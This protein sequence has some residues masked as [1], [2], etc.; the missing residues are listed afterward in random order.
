MGVI[1]NIGLGDGANAEEEE[2]E[3][4]GA[5]DQ[6]LEPHFANGLNTNDRRSLDQD[7]G[8]VVAFEGRGANDGHKSVQ[9]ELGEN[10][11]EVSLVAASFEINRREYLLV[12]VGCDRASRTVPT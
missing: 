6:W 5:G 12:V 10:A 4:S 2:C 1:S 7:F 11:P 8:A 9:D 3:T